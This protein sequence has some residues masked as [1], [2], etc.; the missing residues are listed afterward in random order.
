MRILTWM[1]KIADDDVSQYFAES[2]A[3]KNILDW[4]L[5]NQKINDFLSIQLASRIRLKGL[6][7]LRTLNLS[8]TSYV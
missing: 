5:N 6:V 8:N 2:G 1:S 3:S 4:N 7:E